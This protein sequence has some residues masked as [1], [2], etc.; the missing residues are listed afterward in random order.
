MSLSRSPRKRATRAEKD[1]RQIRIHNWLQAG[2]SIDEIARQER[3]TRKWTRDL[4]ARMLKERSQDAVAAPGA[5]DEIRLEAAL[6][7]A[8]KAIIENKLEG[9]DRL[10]KVIDRLQ[11][12]RGAAKK[13]PYDSDARA[14]L[15]AKLNLNVQRVVRMRE[16]AAEKEAAGNA[17]ESLATP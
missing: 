13:P 10:I 8:A 7:L 17:P 15:L 9:I 2:F 6:R 12:L 11:K 14:R 16:A 1:I 4:I 3:I 5:L